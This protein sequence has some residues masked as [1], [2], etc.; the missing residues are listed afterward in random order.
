MDVDIIAFLRDLFKKKTQEESFV[1]LPSFDNLN[2]IDVKTASATYVTVLFDNVLH[3]QNTLSKL[4]SY[5]ELNKTFPTHLTP[6]VPKEITLERFLLDDNNRAIDHC[7]VLRDIALV[8]HQIH[9]LH[10][11]LSTTE[12]YDYTNKRITPSLTQHTEYLLRLIDNFGSLNET[13]NKYRKH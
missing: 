13:A 2:I 8:N 7:Q 10:E 1:T 12:D 3:Y 5:L 11:R 9:Q 4:L 6:N